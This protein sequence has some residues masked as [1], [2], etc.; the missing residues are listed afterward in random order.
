MTTANKISMIDL[1]INLLK[2]RSAENGSIIKKLERKKR[3]LQA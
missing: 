1:R 2:S 3:S